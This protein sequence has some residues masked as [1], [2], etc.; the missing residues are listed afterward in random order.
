MRTGDFSQTQ[1]STYLG[2]LYGA[3]TMN[4][5]FQVQNCA[6]NYANI[7][8]VPQTGTDGTAITDGNISAYMDPGAKALLDIYPL[9]GS[10]VPTLAQP[11]NYIQ[12]N[13][14]NNDLWQARGR[15]DYAPGEKTKIF[16]VY[17][18]EKGINSVPSI[19]YYQPQAVMGETNTPGGMVQ[20]VHTQ[21]AAINV[22]TII[23][24]SLTNEFYGS[25][26]L[27]KLDYND[28]TDGTT[29]AATGYP[30]DGLYDNGSPIVPQ[31][32]TTGMTVYLSPSIRTTAKASL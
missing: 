21:L 32:K 26:S 24:P 22:S 5:G 6:A 25:A 11:Y 29:K 31:M 10:H 17:N 8:E 3:P 27:F 16:A 20:P 13:L 14:V 2:Q 15:I 23:T 4:N 28:A 1:I 19:P 18:T 30:Y 9:P 7:C 12:T